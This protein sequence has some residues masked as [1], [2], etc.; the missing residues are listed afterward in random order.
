MTEPPKENIKALS[1]L[2]D[3]LLQIMKDM[4]I[5]AS[6]LLSLLFKITNLERTSQFCLVKDPGSREVKDL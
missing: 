3:E 4:G 6:H 5:L 2:D 1:N